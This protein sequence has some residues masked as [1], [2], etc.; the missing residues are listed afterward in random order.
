MGVV[1]ISCGFINSSLMTNNVG[2]CMCPC[3]L[4]NT[5]FSELSV[6]Q[7]PFLYFIDFSFIRFSV[8]LIQV[9]FI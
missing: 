4:T 2:I 8:I 7:F 6:K 9:I 5:I 3:F 1:V